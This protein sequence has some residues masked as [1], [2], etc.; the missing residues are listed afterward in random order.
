[1]ALMAEE[2]V[3][4][5]KRKWLTALVLSATHVLYEMIPDL[6]KCLATGTLRWSYKHLYYYSL[7]LLQVKANHFTKTMLF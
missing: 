4:L 1:M 7:K 5:F 3:I 2:A 6:H